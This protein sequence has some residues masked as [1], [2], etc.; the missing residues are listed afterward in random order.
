MQAVLEQISVTTQAISALKYSQSSTRSLH[1]AVGPTLLKRLPDPPLLSTPNTT[2]A[3][4]LYL[5][6]LLIYAKKLAS[7]TGDQA[8]YDVVDCYNLLYDHVMDHLLKQ[9]RRSSL[10]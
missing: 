3:L 6:K 1:I 5:Q 8:L 7:L 2:D 4:A 9:V 10:S